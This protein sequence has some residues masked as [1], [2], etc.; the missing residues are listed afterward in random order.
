[1]DRHVSFA[2][3]GLSHETSGPK[4]EKDFSVILLTREGRVNKDRSQGPAPALL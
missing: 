3:L 2:F 1:M 4:R